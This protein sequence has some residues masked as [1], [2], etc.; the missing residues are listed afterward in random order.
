VGEHGRSC[1]LST[2]EEYDQRAAECLALA[3]EASDVGR[4]TLLLEMA[5]AW[6]K[7]AMKAKGELPKSET[8]R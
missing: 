7:L 4:K 2:P 6:I 3:H 8:G 5:Q 1:T